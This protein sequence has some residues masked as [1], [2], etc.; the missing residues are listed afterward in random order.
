MT[1]VSWSGKAAL[2]PNAELDSYLDT[3]AVWVSDEHSF[4]ELQ[5]VFR[6]DDWLSPLVVAT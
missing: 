3:I 2:Q 4:G 1:V 5:R 6:A